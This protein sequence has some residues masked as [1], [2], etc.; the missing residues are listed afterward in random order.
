MKQGADGSHLLR[1]CNA[2]CML[3]VTPRGEEGQ[4]AGSANVVR[5]PPVRGCTASNVVPPRRMSLDWPPVKIS[6]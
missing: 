2:R 1:M 5:G 4:G 3:P 6:R